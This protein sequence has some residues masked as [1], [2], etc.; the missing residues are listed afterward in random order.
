VIALLVLVTLTGLRV[1]RSLGN[2]GAVQRA[3][4]VWATMERDFSAPGNLFREPTGRVGHAW[5]FSQAVAAELAMAQLPGTPVTQKA[6]IEKRLRALEHYR[7]GAAYA[8]TSSATSEYY[9]DNEWIALDLVSAYDLLG[10]HQFL[11]G[12]ERLFRFVTAGW[13]R[14]PTHPCSGGVFWVRGSANHDRNTVST[15]N[16]ALVGAELYEIT[17]ATGY[18]TWAE[19]MYDWVDQCLSG[20]DGMYYDHLDLDGNVDRTEWSYNQGA[21]IAAGVLLGKLTGDESY[22]DRSQRIA[23]ATLAALRP[24]N[25]AGQ[26]AIFNAI[27]FRDLELLDHV[28]PDRRYGE[29]L[30]DYVAGLRL[31]HDAPALLAEAALV[32]LAAQAATAH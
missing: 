17:H 7:L 27:F 19:R 18:L 11:A 8:P 23:A 15:A 20:G 28:R 10:E 22:V 6:L 16:G 3:Q 9:D 12:A 24:T 14:D 31:D 32:Q 2:A 25:F 13:D 30:M 29:A 5:P 26:P 21:M 1:H 4:Q